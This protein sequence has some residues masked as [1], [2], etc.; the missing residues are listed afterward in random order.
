MTFAR[1]PPHDTDFLTTRLWDRHMAPHWRE[2]D[3]PTAPLSPEMNKK[4]VDEILR[5]EKEGVPVP[6]E[7]RGRGEEPQSM[8]IKRTMRA[9][10][11]KWTMFPPEVLN[12]RQN[13]DG[14]W[15][16]IPPS[17]KE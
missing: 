7:T 1:F 14:D 5:L 2:M 17:E 16:D 9:R 10:R 12:R 15:E 8:I 3:R 13:A 6:D 4:I 11:G